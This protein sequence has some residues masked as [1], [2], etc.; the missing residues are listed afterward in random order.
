MHLEQ[1]EIK[2]LEMMSF[3]IA[4]ITYAILIINIID[5][6][7]KSLMID[8]TALA[9]HLIRRGRKSELEKELLSKRGK[10]Y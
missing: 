1:L 5:Y 7:N 2:I 10:Q 6:S 8:G 4:L 9:K 3:Y